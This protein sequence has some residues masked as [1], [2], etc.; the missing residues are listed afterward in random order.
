MGLLATQDWAYG[1]TRKKHLEFI[2]S[3]KLL[4]NYQ[5]ILAELSATE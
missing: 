4:K 3:A 5:V 1:S 2:G